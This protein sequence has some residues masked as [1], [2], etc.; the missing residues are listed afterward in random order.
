MLVTAFE[1]TRYLELFAPGR[2]VIGRGLLAFPAFRTH[3]RVARVDAS[4]ALL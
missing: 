4:R 1:A 3:L 2:I